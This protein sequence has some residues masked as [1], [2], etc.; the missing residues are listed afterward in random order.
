MD[1][2][3]SEDLGKEDAQKASRLLEKA[4]IFL[5]TGDFDKAEATLEEVLTIAP[6]HYPTRCNLA[7]CKLQDDSKELSARSKSA[8]RMFNVSDGAIQNTP[9]INSIKNAIA[10]N[11]STMATKMGDFFAAAELF[12]LSQQVQPENPERDQIVENYISGVLD[13]TKKSTLR[14]I[15]S[16]KEKFVINTTLNK[17]LI[18]L[19]KDFQ[20]SRPFVATV[21]NFVY[22]TG[23]WK[24]MRDVELYKTLCSDLSEYEQ[25][26]FETLKFGMFGI[27]KKV[28]SSKLF[29]SISL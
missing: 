1:E 8:V 5:D 17:T 24:Q 10:Y 6:R 18:L 16:K 9:E 15:E 27:K 12:K 25:F 28:A 22:E 13:L 3:L 7:L 20:P 14:E 2:L 21:A 26:D 23:S 29:S 11:I 4:N 19:A